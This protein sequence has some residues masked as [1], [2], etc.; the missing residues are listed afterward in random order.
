M[1]SMLSLWAPVVRSPNSL[2]MLGDMG[3]GEDSIYT[4]HST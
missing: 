2:V 4:Y 1:T 3:T